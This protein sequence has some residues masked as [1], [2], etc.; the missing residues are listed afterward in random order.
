MGFVQIIEFRSSHIED[1][2]GGRRV[3]E[4]HLGKADRSSAHSLRRPRQPR[5]VLQH[6]VLDSYEAAMENSAL[7]KPM[8]LS[9]TMMRLADGPPTFHDLDVRKIGLG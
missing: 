6:R 1:G 8:P 5:S 7:P 4:G 3:G 2:G 9:N